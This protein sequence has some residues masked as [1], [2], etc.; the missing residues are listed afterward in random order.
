MYIAS[1]GSRYEVRKDV[2]EEEKDDITPSFKKSMLDRIYKNP[3]ANFRIPPSP[4]SLYLVRRHPGCKWTL[5][6]ACAVQF[7][8]FFVLGAWGWLIGTGL[9]F[10]LI[11]SCIAEV[12]SL[13]DL[14]L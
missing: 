6:C 10:L 9:R 8:R 4:S 1:L 2:V 11:F 12:I 5:V 3:Y 7:I 14:R 13:F